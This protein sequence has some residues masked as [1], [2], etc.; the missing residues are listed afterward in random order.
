MKF[1]VSELARKINIEQNHLILY[2]NYK[3]K[4]RLQALKEGKI[5]NNKLILV[6]AISPNKAGIGKTT[7]SIAL[8]QGIE[9]IGKKVT[10]A[11]RE[12]SLGPCFGLKGGATGGGKSQL[13][14]SEDINLHFTGDF[15]AITSAHNLIAAILDNY[16]YFQND[17]KIKTVAWKRVADMNDRFLRNIIIGLNGNGIPTESGFDITPSSEI[18]ATICLTQNEKELQERLNKIILGYINNNE[19]LRIKDLQ[20]T[21]SIMSL[22]KEAIQPNLVQTSEGVAA[23]VHGGP[24]ANIAHGCNSLL[25]TKMAMSYG[26]YTVTEA[27]FGADLG[28]EKFF[29]IKSRIG[30]LK[31]KVV[32]L[33]A[34]LRALKVHGGL[35]ESSSLKINQEGLKKGLKNLERHLTNLQSFGPKIVVT[36]NRFEGDQDP[37]IELIKHFCQEKGVLFE[38]NE[39]FSKGGEG[40]IKLGESIIAAAESSEN[41]N[42]KYTYKIEDELETKIWKV[43]KSIYRGKHVKYTKKAKESLNIIK[44][45]GLEQMPICIAK[46][47]FS[48]SDDPK[49]VGAAEDFEFSVQDIIPNTGAGFNVITCGNIIRMPGLPINPQAT[50]IE[51]IEGKIKNIT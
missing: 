18:M 47:P 46:T 35:S 2:G 9:K 37:E 20:I 44:S 12:P 26:D 14:P 40:A 29:N 11:L 8:A 51:Y 34:S 7:T 27:G 10:L 22:L 49:R 45:L 28:A 21:G 6:T 43:V 38:V 5:K 23:F 16:R 13:L 17:R 33:V 1:T 48:F 42:L 25:A 39:G 4:V 15:H 32:V 36:L 3:S 24:F 50:K 30:K 31:P 19:P 41:F